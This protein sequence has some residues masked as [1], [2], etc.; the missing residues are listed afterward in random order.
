MI[1]I[2]EAIDSGSEDDILQWCKE[3][4]ISRARINGVPVIHYAC[5]IGQAASVRILHA[6]VADPNA[7]DADNRTAIDEANWYGEYRMGAY[8]ERSKE[9]VSFLRSVGGR[10]SQPHDIPFWRRP[11]SSFFRKRGA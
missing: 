11:L 1:N 3:N 10:P 8:T 4:D 6:G 9:I 5:R 2:K 7:I